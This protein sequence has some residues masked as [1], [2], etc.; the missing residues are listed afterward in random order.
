MFDLFTYLR[1]LSKKVV[2]KITNHNNTALIA[3]PRTIIITI[4]TR[5][6]L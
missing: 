3:A 5:E 4:T 2:Y 1:L 6:G